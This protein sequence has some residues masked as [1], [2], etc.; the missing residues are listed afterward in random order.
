MHTLVED[1]IKGDHPKAPEEIS[2]KLS[3]PVR[4]VH[5]CL[6]LLRDA[7]LVTE[8]W[9]EAE[10]RYI[11]QPGTDVNR[12]KLSFVLEKLESSGSV[13]KIVINNSDYKKIDSALSKFE[14][15]IDASESNVLLR[16]I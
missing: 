15:L 8:V 7:S 12:M 14:S 3:L 4:T 11:Y 2:L 16:D 5:E 1:F 6:D 10:E 9:D 13:H